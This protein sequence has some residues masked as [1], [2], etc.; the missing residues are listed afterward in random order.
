MFLGMFLRAWRHPVH[1]A[2][3]HSALGRKV[4]SLFAPHRS[5]GPIAVP[6]VNGT[7]L[8]C[9][10]RSED[11]HILRLL[12]LKDF[13]AMSFIA[14]FLR[15]S[16]HFVDVGAGIG[17]YSVLAAVTSGAR[18]SAIEPAAKEA[19]LL[20]CNVIFNQL[21]PRV[22]VLRLGVAELSGRGVMQPNTSSPDRRFIVD[23]C[24]DMQSSVPAH[25][26]DEVL[27]KDG[28]QVLKIAAGGDELAVL[29]GA[30]GILARGSLYAVVVATPKRRD[31]TPPSS[32]RIDALLERHGFVAADYDPFERQLLKPGKAGGKRLYV[33]KWQADAIMRRLQQAGGFR[34]TTALHL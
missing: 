31:N 12:V 8:F 26:L 27:G 29:R 24:A 9:D 32:H 17:S 18:V 16:D 14:H 3:L 1:Q 33:R 6:Y 15:P 10:R 23:P 30:Y 28:V 22:N 5:S 7:W 20:S 25:R 11:A 13:A 19:A 4:A 2:G 34:P 21:Q